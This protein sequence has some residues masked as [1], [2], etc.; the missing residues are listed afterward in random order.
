MKLVFG[1]IIKKPTLYKVTDSS[2]FPF[3]DVVSSESVTAQ[4]TVSRRGREHVMLK[5]VLRGKRRVGCDRCGQPV[6]QIL[7][8]E[9]EY[10]VTTKEEEVSEL[11][12]VECEDEDIFFIYL[13]GPEIKVD[14][15]LQEQ[16]LLAAP[17]RTLCSED[18]KGLCP[19]CGAVL[20]SESCSCSF[21]D[22]RS[23]FAIL[24]KLCNHGKK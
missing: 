21:D 24:G 12:D 10:Q 11:Q 18:C 15:I 17:L 19:G 2:W 1:E 7:D 13:D 16:A 8:S 6:E 23:P 9:F 22:N 14:E 20:S 5:G 4:V 3:N